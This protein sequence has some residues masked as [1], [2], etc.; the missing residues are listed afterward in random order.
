MEEIKFITEENK[1][2]ILPLTT[3]VAIDVATGKFVSNNAMVA[4]GIEIKVSKM[5]VLAKTILFKATSELKFG[6][7][8]HIVNDMISPFQFSSTMFETRKMEEGIVYKIGDKI[9]I[10][11]S[12]IGNDFGV[13]LY[14]NI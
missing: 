6:N 14:G 9:E 13:I 7:F 12:E 10:T 8:S 2:K 3:I 1:I 4:E 11:E 5:K